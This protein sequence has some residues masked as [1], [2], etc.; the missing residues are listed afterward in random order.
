M[1]DTIWY[2]HYRKILN[3]QCSKLL[4]IRVKPS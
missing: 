4:Q 2:I 3:L 1:R